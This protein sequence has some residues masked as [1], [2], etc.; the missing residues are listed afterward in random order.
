M[1]FVRRAWDAM[2]GFAFGL[3]NLLFS[4]LYFYS[5]V[6]DELPRLRFNLRV[7]LSAIYIGN[8]ICSDLV[9]CAYSS[10]SSL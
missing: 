2:V 6:T 10:D 9:G 8:A 5:F 4:D 1:T 3:A 7:S